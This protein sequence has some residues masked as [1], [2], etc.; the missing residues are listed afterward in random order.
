MKIGFI[1]LGQ[2]GLPMA[3]NLLR[4]GHEVAVYNRTRSRAESLL[5]AGG[6]VA[7]SP[8]EAAAGAEIVVTILS[9]DRAL[10]E[11]VF[12]AEGLLRGLPSGAIHM[13]P[14]PPAWP[15]PRPL[16]EP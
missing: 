1:G 7:A 14:T 10:E 6:H 2:M 8:G 15:R 4:A 3:R 13:D 9:D 11:V 12:G 16:P 5:S